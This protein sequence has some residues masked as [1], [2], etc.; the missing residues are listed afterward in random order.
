[1]DQNITLKVEWILLLMYMQVYCKFHLSIHF[2]V[3]T[4]AADAVHDLFK[5][6]VDGAFGSYSEASGGR[7]ASLAYTTA[8]RPHHFLSAKKFGAIKK[9]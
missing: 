8:T 6:A 9:N 4:I 7:L 1:M 3:C 2:T 5:L